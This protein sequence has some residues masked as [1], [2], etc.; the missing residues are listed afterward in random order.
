M[1]VQLVNEWPTRDGFDHDQ[2]TVAVFC[3]DIEGSLCCAYSSVEPLLSSA[4][5]LPPVRE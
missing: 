1:V 4:L 5:C 3:C 2:L